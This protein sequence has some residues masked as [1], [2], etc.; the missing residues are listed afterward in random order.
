MIDNSCIGN[1][2]KTSLNECK[3]LRWTVHMLLHD[4]PTEVYSADRHQWGS[5]L[6]DVR[7]K[8]FLPPLVNVVCLE[9]PPPPS[10]DVRIVSRVKMSETQNILRSGRLWT[11]VGDF[12]LPKRNFFGIFGR[13]VMADLPP[14]PRPRLSTIILHPSPPLL[15]GRL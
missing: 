4:G 3:Y 8:T 15:T 5:S 2:N 7:P 9:H 13:L 10:T 1:H 11:E 6:K 12:R 14:P